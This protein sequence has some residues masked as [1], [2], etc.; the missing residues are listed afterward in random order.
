MV[1][2][3]GVVVCSGRGG[4]GVFREGGV[5]WCVPGG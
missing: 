1:C 3:R 5:V 4:S 2:S